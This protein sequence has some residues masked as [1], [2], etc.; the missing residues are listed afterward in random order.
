MVDEEGEARQNLGMITLRSVQCAAFP[1]CN[2]LLKT[3]KR[4]D[5]ITDVFYRDTPTHD[6]VTG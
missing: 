3:E 2:V 4:R 6:R 1:H 5:L